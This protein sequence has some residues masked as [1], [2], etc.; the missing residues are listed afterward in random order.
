VG[1]QSDAHDLPT[2]LLPVER[3]TMIRISVIS[4]DLVSVGYDSQNQL[5]EI[6][7]KENAV[8]QYSGVPSSVHEG[9]MNATS[10][11]KYVHQY[12][13]QYRNTRVS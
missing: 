11:G 1:V 10:K 9:L 12:V 7:F 8:Y 5:L 13:K 6:E 2:W 4:S 3:L